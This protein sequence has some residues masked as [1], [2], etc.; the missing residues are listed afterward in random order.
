MSAF[1]LVAFFGFAGGDISVTGEASVSLPPDH[2]SFN[3]SVVTKHAEASTALTKN[4]ET[5]SAVV[6]ALAGL[7]IESKCIQTAMFNLQYTAG[8]R[9]PGIDESRREP[10]G[11]IV[12][13]SMN[14]IVHKIADLGKILDQ[15]VRAG[16]NDVQDIRF[17]IS[18]TRYNRDD[19]ERQAVQNAMDKARKLAVYADVSLGALK[20]LQVGVSSYRPKAYAMNELAPASAD[21]PIQQ[22]ESKITVTV[23]MVYESGP[24]GGER[25]KQPSVKR[26]QVD[27]SRKGVDPQIGVDP[28]F[29]PKPV[30]SKELD[31]YFVPRQK[32]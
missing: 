29:A 25:I 3:F 9:N 27:E 18:P 8:N 10:P 22:G 4:S 26:G 21:V 24:S 13:N 20:S 31:Q 17:G 11:Y 23:G 5:T 19:L 16:A 15:V 14:V 32:G 7:G 30:K 1:V 28:L 2:A 12:S 6:A